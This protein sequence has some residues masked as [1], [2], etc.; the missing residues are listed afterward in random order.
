MDI[1]STPFT[2]SNADNARRFKR[3]V[4]DVRG[5][6]VTN[7]EIVR[8]G[9]LYVNDVNINPD[10]VSPGGQVT[11]KV[12]VA[13][14]AAFVSPF[15]PDTCD[16]PNV[17]TMEGIRG[18]VTADPD[19]TSPDARTFCCAMWKQATGREELHFSFRAP[20]LPSGVQREQHVIN[21]SLELP[22]SGTGPDTQ[23]FT[24]SVE[25][26]GSTGCSTNTDC[27]DGFACLDGECVPDETGGGSGC[28]NNG[29]CLTGQVC[30]DGSCE[31]DTGGGGGGLFGDLAE[32]VKQAMYVF[33]G[34]MLLFALATLYA[35]SQ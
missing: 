7:Q 12:D 17:M 14:D 20:D 30:N 10:P 28:T 15:D 5:R 26:D 1:H 25:A 24:L 29:D 9:R 8:A 33:M 3:R 32:D 6:A 27:D 31:W 13:E 2:G 4:R 16:P 19:W 22:G 34:L 23:S 18:K 35:S 21:V 11:V